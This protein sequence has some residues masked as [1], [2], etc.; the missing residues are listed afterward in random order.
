MIGYGQVLPMWKLEHI[1]HTH[2]LLH[3][4][5]WV[6]Y[7]AWKLHNVPNSDSPNGA[8]VIAE[9]LAEELC[10]FMRCPD[11]WTEYA[12]SATATHFFQAAGSLVAMIAAGWIPHRGSS[13]TCR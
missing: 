3:V 9:E 4:G 7:W 11:V 12:W 2:T 6:H 5:A 10:S 8:A 13:C 1:V